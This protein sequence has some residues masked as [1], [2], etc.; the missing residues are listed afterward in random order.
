MSSSLTVSTKL[1]VW[2]KQCHPIATGACQ[3]KTCETLLYPP[4]SITS[5]FSRSYN[6]FKFHTG[7]FETKEPARFAKIKTNFAPTANNVVILC[8]KCYDEYKYSG[9]PENDIRQND[10]LMLDLS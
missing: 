8:G 5:K 1:N 9:V 4:N 7:Y 2:E 6:K 10:I 3:C